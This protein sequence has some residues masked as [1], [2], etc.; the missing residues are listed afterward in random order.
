VRTQRAERRKTPPLPLFPTQSSA[1]HV[2]A[3]HPKWRTEAL[4]FCE[5]ARLE[6]RRVAR[7]RRRAAGRRG[8]LR[9][10]RRAERL[11]AARHLDRG[12]DSFRRRL[13]LLVSCAIL[14]RGRHFGAV[15]DVKKRGKNRRKKRA[16][17]RGREA[18]QGSDEKLESQSRKKCVMYHQFFPSVCHVS[19]RQNLAGVMYHVPGAAVCQVSSP[20]GA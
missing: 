6:V 10:R 16:S 7:R 5:D 18:E 12:V 14:R 11:D 13:H 2:A 8:A 3:S 15:R 1:R 20:A 19:P 9:K 4:D 17:S